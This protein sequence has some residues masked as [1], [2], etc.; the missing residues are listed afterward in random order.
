[1]RRGNTACAERLWQQRRDGC[2]TMTSDQPTFFKDFCT[3]QPNVLFSP[4]STIILQKCKSS[5]GKVHEF[6]TKVPRGRHHFNSTCRLERQGQLIYSGG[7]IPQGAGSITVTLD[8]RFEEA[9]R[10]KWTRAVIATLSVITALIIWFSCCT[11]KLEAPRTCHG[12]IMNWVNNIF[13]A[14]IP[15][16][17]L[18]KEV[19]LAARENSGEEIRLS[20]ARRYSR[21][22]NS[23]KGREDQESSDEAEDRPTE[24]DHSS[25]ELASTGSVPRVVPY[26]P[27]MV[28]CGQP[29]CGGR[30]DQ[31]TYTMP[32]M[33]TR[34]SAP[35][36]EPH[37]EDPKTESWLR[38]NQFLE[39]R[40]KAG[41]LVADYG[42]GSS[43][44]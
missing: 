18:K 28:E 5:D 31:G 36:V 3:N 25:R 23:S 32:R 42:I 7:T 19:K 40:P 9:W 15:C 41:S 39:K 27:I 2:H 10:S 35:H 13:I 37:L 21:G 44:K 30:L 26:R 34:A 33:D 20:L 11:K 29:T 16:I 22:S 8:H 12:Y 6:P 4:V 17:E 43:Y 38:R 24:Y 1:M 14:C